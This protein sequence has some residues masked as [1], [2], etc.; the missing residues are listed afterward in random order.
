MEYKTMKKQIILIK[1]LKKYPN[2]WHSYATD[3]DTI[4]C[5][6][7]TA[8]IGILKLNE[9]GQMRL[10]SIVKANDFLRVRDI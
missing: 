10:K 6:C 4:E 7:A 2:K 1:F 8:N 5:I 9:H 3:R